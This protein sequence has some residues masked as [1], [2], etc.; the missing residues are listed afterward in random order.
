MGI[1]VQF[2]EG[3]HVRT[4]CDPKHYMEPADVIVL[5]VV[6]I[7]RSPPVDD[8]LHTPPGRRRRRQPCKT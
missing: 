2:P 1:I 4:Q 3:H 5:P 8:G 7:E 6:C